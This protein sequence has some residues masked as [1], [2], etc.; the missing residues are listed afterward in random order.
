MARFREVRLPKQVRG[1]ILQDQGV[2][3]YKPQGYGITKPMGYD[4][5]GPYKSNGW[6]RFQPDDQTAT[7]ALIYYPGGLV[8]PDAYAVTGQAIAEAGYL[9]II[10]DMPLN[11]AFLATNEADDIIAAHPQIEKWVIGGHS[12]GG[13]MAA[14]Y[15]FDHLETIEGLILFASYPASSI[16]FSTT[17]LP[18]LSIYGSKDFGIDG[19]EASLPQLPPEAILKVLEGGN[20]CAQQTLGDAQFG[21]Y[22]EQEGDGIATISRQSQQEQIIFETVNFLSNLP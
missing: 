8:E 18:I 6:Y 7:T 16:D 1:T 19:I 15:A 5:T 10:P 21:D 20:Q 4:I 3:Y 12:L 14:E 22:G 2:R 9:V 11:L 13:S 17:T